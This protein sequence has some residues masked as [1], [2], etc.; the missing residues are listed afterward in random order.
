M[1]YLSMRVKGDSGVN[2]YDF[3]KTDPEGYVPRTKR[4]ASAVPKRETMLEEIQRAIDRR[5]G[6]DARLVQVCGTYGSPEIIPYYMVTG[7]TVAYKF[8]KDYPDLRKGIKLLSEDIVSIIKKIL[9][10]DAEVGERFPPEVGEN[11]DRMDI[12][13]T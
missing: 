7:G 10:P 4:A 8:V 1:L 2:L 3:I 11:I 6:A 12:P 13:H 9:G 5:L